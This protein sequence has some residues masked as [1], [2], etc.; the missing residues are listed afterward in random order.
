MTGNLLTESQTN[1]PFSRRTILPEELTKI[2]VLYHLKP[3][4]L[5]QTK[6][7]QAKMLTICLYSWG[8]LLALEESALVGIEECFR[9]V[10]HGTIDLTKMQWDTSN[11]RH[12]L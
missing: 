9:V 2:L 8:C 5:V 4:F 3:N 1:S 10:G 7:Y 12:Q 6:L 11:I